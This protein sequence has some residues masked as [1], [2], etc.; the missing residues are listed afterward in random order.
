MGV[1]YRAQGSGGGGIMRVR[2]TVAFQAIRGECV[3]G[4]GHLR[5]GDTT[6]DG[7]SQWG[8]EQEGVR[9]SLVAREKGLARGKPI[10]LRLEIENVGSRVIHYDPTQV[11]INSSMYIEGN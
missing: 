10:L 9:A 1:H 5:S 2:R 11:A 6:N 3:A 4:S 7:L 8:P